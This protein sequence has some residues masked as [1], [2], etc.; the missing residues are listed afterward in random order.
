MIIITGLFLLVIGGVSGYQL[1]TF[2]KWVE[3]QQNRAIQNHFNV[4]SNEYTYFVEGVEDGFI[5]SLKDTEYRIK[6]SAN[7]PLKVVFVEELAPVEGS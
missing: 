1:A 7:K 2:P 5:L 3:I 4:K 6:F